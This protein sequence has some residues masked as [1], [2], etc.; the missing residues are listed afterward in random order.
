MSKKIFLSPCKD[1]ITGRFGL[2][3]FYS[4]FLF[5]DGSEIALVYFRIGYA[6]RQYPTETVSLHPHGAPFNGT[7]ICGSMNMNQAL[8]FQIIVR[9]ASYQYSVHGILK[10]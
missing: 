4:F 10:L 8:L 2:S 1:I 5:R 6:P 3:L 9:I 7:M